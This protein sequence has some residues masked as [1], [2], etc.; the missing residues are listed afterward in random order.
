MGALHTEGLG[1]SWANIYLWIAQ[2][3]D[4]KNRGD[5]AFLEDPPLPGHRGR[6]RGRALA[7][8]LRPLG[9]RAARSGSTSSNRPPTKDKAHETLHLHRRDGRSLLHRHARQVREARRRG[10]RDDRRR[11]VARP[12]LPRRPAARRQGRAQGRAEGDRGPRPRDRRA[13]LLGEPA[14][15][16]PDGRAPPQGDGSRPSASPARSA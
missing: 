11:L 6:H 13:Q 14:R 5:E 7:G 3:I 10:H 15:S 16:R 2:A 12:A 4:A 8:E 1:D 9:R